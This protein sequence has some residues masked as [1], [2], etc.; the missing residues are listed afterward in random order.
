MGSNRTGE[1]PPPA[2]N[3]PDGSWASSAGVRRSMRSNR[4]E[5]TTPEVLVRSELQRAGLRF[6]KHFRPHPGAR[7]TI[8][9]AFTK[10]RLGVF[11]DGCFWHGCPDHKRVRPVTNAAWWAEKLDGNIAR[12]RT[13]DARLRAD[14]WTILRCW[15]HE[16]VSSVVARVA[17]TL[18]DLQNQ[19]GE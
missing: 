10:W 13:T 16:D 3:G 5:D 15:E 4:S 12:D 9:I 14:G 2:V 7:T 18:R 1:M 17:A 11:V 8:D 19:A 6:R